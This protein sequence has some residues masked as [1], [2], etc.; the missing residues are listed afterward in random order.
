MLYE[1]KKY[2]D[3]INKEIEQIDN[4]LLHLPKGKLIVVKDRNS[5][6]WYIAKDGKQEYL[7]KEYSEM[8][9]NL[10][11][12]SY[13]EMKKS[14]LES[15]ASAVKMYL[16]HS[17]FNKDKEYEVLV[18]KPGFA[19]L[20]QS[21]FGSLSEELSAWAA[22][23]F[24]SN[25]YHPEHLT[26]PSISGHMLRSKSEGAIDAFLFT[27]N[28]PFRYEEELIVDGTAIYPD[29]TIRHPQSGQFYYWAHL[30][31][32]D[33]PSYVRRKAEELIKLVKVGI[34]PGVNLIL[35][36]ETKDH[37]LSML[38]VKEIVEKYFL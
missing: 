13:L 15:E 2:L 33:D 26:I 28:I 4:Q 10:A 31:I 37:Q 3:E 23:S 17:S 12:R 5:F 14:Y 11:M 20:L 32:I 18:G 8:A 21:Q 35:T 9:K 27:H 25:P 24:P 38:D 30:G 7:K 29:F 1:M 36:F 19:P 6:R 22:A 34:I 16:R